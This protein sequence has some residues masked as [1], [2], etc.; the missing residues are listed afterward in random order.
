MIE[1]LFGFRAKQII[2]EWFD[3]QEY[4]V[5]YGDWRLGLSYAFFRKMLELEEWDDFQT[6]T[7]ALLIFERMG[8]IIPRNHFGFPLDFPLP[9]R[10][11][12]QACTS[13][14]PRFFRLFQQLNLYFQNSHKL[15][16]SFRVVHINGESIFLG[17]EYGNRS[18]INL[19]E[20][21]FKEMIF[22]PGTI[23]EL[24]FN[25]GQVRDLNLSSSVTLIHFSQISSLYPLRHSI[26]AFRNPRSF[27]RI[28]RN[29]RH[30]TSINLP[31]EFDHII[32]RLVDRGDISF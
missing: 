26:W 8:V 14:E 24:D 28:W 27:K 12:F 18:F 23:W 15:E 19:R 6:K 9:N 29:G 2:P 4:R 5:S 22:P 3:P 17:K 16:Q 13:A 32:S 1:R 7:Q 11:R 25:G 31:T 21:Y 20:V 10:I 30:I